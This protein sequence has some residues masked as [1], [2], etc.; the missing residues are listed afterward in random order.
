MREDKK[1]KKTNNE[2]GIKKKIIDIQNENIKTKKTFYQHV[3]SVK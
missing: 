2:K 3:C 1:K